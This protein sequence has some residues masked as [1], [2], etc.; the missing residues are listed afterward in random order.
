MLSIIICSISPERLQQVSQNIK[1]T[2]GVE[3]EIISIDNREKKWS[4]ARVYNEGA[5]KALY[6]Y[7]FFVHED[8]K[9]H[10]QDWG[11]VI[12]KKLEEPNCGVIGFAGTKA[13]LRCYS[14]WLQNHQW[15]C[16]LLYQ[17]LNEG[18]T[19]LRAHQAYLERP[20]EEVVALDGLGMFVRKEV[21]KAYPFDEALLT[22]FH[23]YDVD[24]SLQIAASKKYK[25]YVCCSTKVLIEHFSS[26]SLNHSWYKDTIRFHKQKWNKILPMQIDDLK[27]SRKDEKKY[28]ERC[29]NYF[30]R[31]ILQTDYPERK[32]VL[33]EFLF[34]S[35]SWKHLGHCISNLYK[36]MK[37]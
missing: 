22:G 30:V 12:E 15:M 7:L 9:F 17:G 33:K 2:I 31:G 1:D 34:C 3:H 23:C 24:F 32:L 8:V 26:G 6:P 20:F 35:F 27:L 4:I 19:E 18:L 29:F 21:W 14:G 37:S 36:Y 11:T 13:M 5:R 10:S 16:L 28:R 25:N